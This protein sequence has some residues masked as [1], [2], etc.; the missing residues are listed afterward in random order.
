MNN[1]YLGMVR[2]WQE[3]FHEKRYSSTCL[4][5]C[6]RRGIDCSGDIENC[7]TFIPD[8]V[9]L[10]ESYGAAGIRVR[11]TEDLNQAIRKALETKGV[12]VVLDIL[13]ERE[14]NVWPMIPAGAS[15][16]E[17]MKGGAAI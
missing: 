11:K 14:E 4:L 7:F 2:Q 6:S 17:M 9:K 12:P 5:N 13:T 16:D 8:F 10:A 3:L 1:G 15:V